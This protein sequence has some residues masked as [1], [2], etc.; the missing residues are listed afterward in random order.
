VVQR[1]YDYK[2]QKFINH[3]KHS[4]VATQFS[5]TNRIWSKKKSESKKSTKRK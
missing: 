5:S 4:T 1:K 2:Q 3:N